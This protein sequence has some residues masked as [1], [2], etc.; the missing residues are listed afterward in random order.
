MET[1]NIMF[2]ANKKLS[3]KNIIND[4]I[5]NN[6]KGEN[7]YKKRVVAEN[8]TF[9]TE[10]Y[11]YEN[12]LNNIKNIQSNSFIFNDEKTKITLQQKP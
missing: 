7:K 3:K 4:N 6:N 11:I 2:N 12:Q 8:W 5:I 1:K 9:E 10:D